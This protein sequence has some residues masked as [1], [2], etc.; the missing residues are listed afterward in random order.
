MGLCAV[1]SVSLYYP[2][3]P[4]PAPSLCTAALVKH[5]LGESVPVSQASF[6]SRK[7]KSMSSKQHH[8]SEDEEEEEEEE[9]GRLGGGV[10]RTCP[11]CDYLLKK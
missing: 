6:F 3:H 11:D 1:C 7:K 8:L 10:F 5:K 2:P 9:H 4:S